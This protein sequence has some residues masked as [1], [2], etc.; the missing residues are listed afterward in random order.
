M[1]MTVSE[2][3]KKILSYL[4]AFLIAILFSLIVFRPLLVK[5]SQDRKSVV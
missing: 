5:N 3:D 1:K 2:N 4:V